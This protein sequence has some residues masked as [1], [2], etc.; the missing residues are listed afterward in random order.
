ML[1]VPSY[2]ILAGYILPVSNVISSL[3]FMFIVMGIGIGIIGSIISLRKY[4]RV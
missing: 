1:N 4:L 3:F 2:S